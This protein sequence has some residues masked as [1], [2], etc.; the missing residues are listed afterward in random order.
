MRRLLPSYADDVDLAQAYAYPGDRPWL[1]A[2]M[3]SSVDG[4]ATASGL[5][6]GLSG[7]ADRQVFRILRALAD[8]VLVGAGTVRAEGYGPAKVGADL[9]PLRDGLTY[10]VP[11]L[12]V[13]SNRLDLDPWL[14]VFAEA[15]VRSIVVTAGSSPEDRRAALA[16]VA[17]V[18]VAGETTVDPHGAVAMLAERGLT[19]LLCEGGPTLLDQVAAAGRLDELCLTLSPVLVGG[20]ARR[21]VSGPDLEPPAAMALGHALE[22]DGF[23]LLRYVRA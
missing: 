21:I 23:L 15:A 22:Q 3:V 1:R 4:A 19:R 11:V 6:A 17:D 2:N 13:V 10:P 18:V 7:D 20:A 14:P 12:A 9:A 5:S 8:A 16:E